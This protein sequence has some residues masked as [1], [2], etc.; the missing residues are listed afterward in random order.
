MAKITEKYESI[1][2]FSLK[3]DEDTIQ[4]LIKKLSDTITE[5]G[6]TFEG[7]DEW[8]K[9][10]LAYAINYETEGYYVLFNYTGDPQLPAEFDRVCKI[11]DGII[12]YLSVKRI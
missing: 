6:G 9:R 11:T 2:V 10:R 7:I 3:S 12:R 8:G 4:A 1:V 5:N